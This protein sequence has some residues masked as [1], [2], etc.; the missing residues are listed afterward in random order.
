MLLNGIMVRNKTAVTLSFL[1]AQVEMTALVVFFDI[2][3]RGITQRVLF[4]SAVC[5]LCYAISFELLTRRGSRAL[6]HSII[7]SLIAGSV[8]YYVFDL[9]YGIY[10]DWW[11][12]SVHMDDLWSRHFATIFAFQSLACLTYSLFFLVTYSIVRRLAVKD[13]QML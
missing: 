11:Y 13:Q 1:L 9:A 12:M 4:R 2:E 10:I 6:G 7:Y 3:G 5:F 8:L